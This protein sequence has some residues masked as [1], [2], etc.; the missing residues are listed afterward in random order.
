MYESVPHTIVHNVPEFC[1]WHIDVEEKVCLDGRENACR[2]QLLP[3]AAH[4]PCPWPTPLPS[5]W[6]PPAS[7]LT[8]PARPMAAPVPPGLSC[9]P[10]SFRTPPSTW[11][12]PW[13]PPGRQLLNVQHTD[14]TCCVTKHFSLALMA[15][16]QPVSFSLNEQHEMLNILVSAAQFLTI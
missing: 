10:G 8:V 11:P 14:D 1:H 16:P 3:L 13:P 9:L 6:P 5:P 12:S 4:C 7:P 15:E 2:P